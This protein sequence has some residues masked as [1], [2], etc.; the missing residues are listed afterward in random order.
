MLPLEGIGVLV[1]RPKHQ[2]APLCRALGAQGAH[3]A[4]FPALEIVP[5]AE[6]PDF[7][8]RMASGE[9]FDLIVFSSANAVRHGAPL[10]GERS[11]LTLAA[12]GPATA[13]ALNQAGYRVAVQSS[14]GADSESLLRHPKLNAVAGSRVLLIKG[15]GGRD[16]LREELMRRGATVTSIDV[17]RRERR[18]P[19]P[20]E[21]AALA[22]R[23]AAREIQAITATSVETGASLLALAEGGLGAA[24]AGLLWVVP[25]E[26]VAAALHEAGC[27]G[28][29][30]AA[31]SAEDQDLVAAL[32]RWRASESGE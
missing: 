15:S 29:L 24:L 11:G 31:R 27:R 28:T 26:R 1:T 25:G 5:L 4:R 2:A 21:C 19:D 23:L 12:V 18:N 22:A 9:R 17:Y 32:V 3:V 16:L 6:P 7:K 8:T 10:L 30:L 20:G 13:R 14:E